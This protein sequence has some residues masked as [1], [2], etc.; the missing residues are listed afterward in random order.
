METS[1]ATSIAWDTWRL[2][3]LRAVEVNTYAVNAVQESNALSAVLRLNTAALELNTAMA[4]TIAFTG[5]SK[6]FA[7]MSIYQQRMERGIHKSLTTLRGLQAERKQARQHEL[8]EE[9]TLARANDINDL[10]YDAPPAPTENGYVFSNR[11]I[12]T[13]AHRLT[14]LKAAKVTVSQAKPRV[15]FAA[16]ASS[17]RAVTPYSLQTWPHPQAA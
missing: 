16:A 6:N 3:H 12:L 17:G 13:A 1:L 7:L 10:S 9:I 2:N 8:E 5:Q 14:L 4:D 15:Q 11:E